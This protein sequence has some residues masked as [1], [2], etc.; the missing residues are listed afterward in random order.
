MNKNF[1][2]FPLKIEIDKSKEIDEI[3]H[4]LN[5]ENPYKISKHQFIMT[6]INE[7]IKQIKENN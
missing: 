2:R 1:I 7:K 3:V 6:I 5:M 4:Q